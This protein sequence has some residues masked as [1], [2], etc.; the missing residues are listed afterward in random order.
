VP[1]AGLADSARELLRAVVKDPEIVARFRAKVCVIPGSPCTWGRSAL[2]GRGHGRKRT[3]RPGRALSFVPGR[4]GAFL[5]S[6]TQAMV[7]P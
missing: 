2:S 6:R 1:R 5:L 7:R 3:D 4:H